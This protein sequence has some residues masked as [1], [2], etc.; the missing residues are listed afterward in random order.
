MTDSHVSTLSED[1][2]NVDVYV[3]GHHSLMTLFH[4]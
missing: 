1:A 2:K 4:E 3:L